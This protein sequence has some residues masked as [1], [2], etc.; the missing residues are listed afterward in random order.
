M[1]TIITTLNHCSDKVRENTHEGIANNDNTTTLYWR[2]RSLCSLSPSST[3][4][5]MIQQ[6]VWSDLHNLT[7]TTTP[8][9]TSPTFSR[10]TFT[11][12]S[13][14]DDDHYGSIYALHSVPHLSLLY[15]GR[16]DGSIQQQMDTRRNHLSTSV[17]K[18][19]EST[20]KCF[21]SSSNGSSSSNSNGV[22]V[23][24]GGTND[25]LLF[26]GSY[27]GFVKVWDSR[28]LFS[29]ISIS[30]KHSG[31]VNTV[32]CYGNDRI[33]T[34]SIDGIN[35]PSKL[36]LLKKFK[37]KYVKYCHSTWPIHP[38]QVF[39]QIISIFHARMDLFVYLT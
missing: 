27:D 7:S 4:M 38:H 34:S 15:I 20:V 5:M 10:R 6:Q 13:R 32:H 21:S 37:Q 16:H 1:Q 25:H 28:K 24:G 12:S 22:G 18:A 8:T 29:P 39:I 19:H 23:G 33:V 26:S 3:P 36:E 9:F 17:V 30:P 2:K 14:H 35:K 31:Y 11:P